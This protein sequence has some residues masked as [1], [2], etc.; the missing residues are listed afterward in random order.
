[1][2]KIPGNIILNT[3]GVG[4]IFGIGLQGRPQ[5]D[6]NSVLLT[7]LMIRAIR[8]ISAIERIADSCATIVAMTRTSNNSKNGIFSIAKR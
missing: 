7:A 8:G 3:I 1:M 4:M 2:G 6:K 5:F